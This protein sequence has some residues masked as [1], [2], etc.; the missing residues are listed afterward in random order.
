[1]ASFEPSGTD[2][3]PSGFGSARD[4]G[5]E[6]FSRSWT[7]YL[8]TREVLV[9]R[10]ASSRARRVATRRGSTLPGG[11]TAGFERE[12]RASVLGD[13]CG[14]EIGAPGGLGG[15]ARDAF[16]MVED[17]ET[18]VPV[19]T[20]SCGMDASALAGTR[21][22]SVSTLA[23]TCGVDDLTSTESACCGGRYAAAV[24]VGC[25]LDSP[26]FG[27]TCGMDT[28]ALVGTGELD[29][30]VLAETCGMGAAAFAEIF[31]F[32][33]GGAPAVIKDC[34][35]MGSDTP[36][37]GDMGRNVSVVAGDRGMDD[38]ALVGGCRLGAD[39]G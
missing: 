9:R 30:P 24:A 37:V 25:G 6:M 16:E 22:M 29:A 33:E 32:E 36:V 27:E 20:S 39:R 17:D 3:A 7:G 21:E 15:D 8:S 2:A 1:M 5:G 23:G 14:D 35:G 38:P 4:G 11:F 19:F 28:R 34:C 31:C 10:A 13:V 12:S 18:D 26:V